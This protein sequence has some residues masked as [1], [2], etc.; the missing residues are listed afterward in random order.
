M[1]SHLNSF[2]YI[3]GDN[4]PPFVYLEYRPRIVLP[5]LIFFYYI[6]AGFLLQNVSIIY[7]H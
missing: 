5:S 7:F 6:N 4:P 3:F 1:H 2:E